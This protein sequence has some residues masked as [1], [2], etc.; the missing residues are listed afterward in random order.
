MFSPVMQLTAD[1]SSKD[2]GRGE[3]R[4]PGAA[5]ERNSRPRLRSEYP[6]H[7][8]VVVGMSA[9]VGVERQSRTRLDNV[10]FNTPPPPVTRQP[11]SKR[12]GQAPIRLS[13]NGQ[14]GPAHSEKDE[15]LREYLGTYSLT[16]RLVPA[17]PQAAKGGQNNS[18][19]NSGVFRNRSPGK[20][21]QSSCFKIPET[22]SQE[23]IDALEVAV[24]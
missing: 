2:H 8:R 4:G 15:E 21:R 1:K 14:N 9:T 7:P 6:I 3:L 11:W 23:E 10:A 16:L 13:V 19:E 24:R 12:N 17:P 20:I 22:P 18:P 5:P